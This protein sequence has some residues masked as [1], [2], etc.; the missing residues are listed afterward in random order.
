MFRDN[1]TQLNSFY[2]ELLFNLPQF[3]LGNKNIRKCNS[4]SP[5]KKIIFFSMQCK[6]CLYTQVGFFTS[7]YKLTKCQN[8]KLLILLIRI[9]LNW[10]VHNMSQT[11]SRPSYTSRRCGE[12]CSSSRCKLFKIFSLSLVNCF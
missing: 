5:E 10:T 11:I 2:T 4:A 1:R 7:T 12:E 9:E 3:G 6:I 8:Q